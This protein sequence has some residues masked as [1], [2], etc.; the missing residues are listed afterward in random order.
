MPLDTVQQS[1]VAGGGAKRAHDTWEQEEGSRKRH[2][3]AREERRRTLPDPCTNFIELRFQLVRFKG[4]YRVARLPLT[5]TFANLYMF[6]LYIFGW[7]G[8]HSH[9]FEV[10]GCVQMY[11]AQYKK[12]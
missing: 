1:A 7:S 10:V 8:Y 9:R 11:S 5:F 2:K 3:K 12:G 4:V 6:I